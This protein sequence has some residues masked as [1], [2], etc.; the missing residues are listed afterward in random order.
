[1]GVDKGE[2]YPAC[3]RVFKTLQ[4]PDIRISIR[5]LHI[6]PH[7]IR[8]PSAYHRPSTPRY[9]SRPV[10]VFRL[11]G[12]RCTPQVRIHNPRRRF[13]I[14]IQPRR[15][16]YATTGFNGQVDLG[17]GVFNIQRPVKTIWGLYYQSILCWLFC[18]GIAVCGDHIVQGEGK[19]SKLG[20]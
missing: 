19:S 11:R 14:K 9:T 6:H 16:N 3:C 4:R 7:T 18:A 2:Q 20:V 12:F 13:R 17:C 15:F 8:A 10:P 1:M 5:A